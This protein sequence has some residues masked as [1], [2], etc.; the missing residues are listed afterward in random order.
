MHGV[1]IY[2]AYKNKISFYL[3]VILAMDALTI[4]SVYWA[5]DW[6]LSPTKCSLCFLAE[7]TK[8]SLS[9][10]SPEIRWTTLTLNMNYIV[11]LNGTSK[12]IYKKVLSELFCCTSSLVFW[13]KNKREFQGISDQ[14]GQFFFHVFMIADIVKKTPFF[15]LWMPDDMIVL[16]VVYINKTAFDFRLLLTILDFFTFYLLKIH[17]GYSDATPKFDCG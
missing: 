2:I 11:Y 17:N 12:V 5:V 7:K 14:K 9:S 15:K 6:G 13:D 10:C 4:L 1:S 16:S 3:F 8:Q